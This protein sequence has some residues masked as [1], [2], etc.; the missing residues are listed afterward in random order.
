MNSRCR[1]LADC[2]GQLWGTHSV[3][4]KLQEGHLDSNIRARVTGVEAQMFTFDF[5]FGVSL[6]ALILWHSDNLRNLC[7]MRAYVSSRGPRIGQVDTRGSSIFPQTRAVQDSF[8]SQ[9]VTKAP[10]TKAP[11]DWVCRWSLS[12]DQLKTTI[13]ALW[14]T[15]SSHH[16]YCN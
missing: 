15:W 5:L 13:G 4:T 3:W 10:S 9:S 1:I 16:K 7:S 11:G 2:A 6:G 14:G 8:T 12:Y